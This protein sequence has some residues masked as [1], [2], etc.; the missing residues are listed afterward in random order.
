M[1][2]AA[3]EWMDSLGFNE[4]VAVVSGKRCGVQWTPWM[5][6]WFNSLSPRN[7]NS[8]AEGPWDH[9]V[10]LA[11]RILADPMTKLVRPEVYDETYRG[12]DLYSAAARPLTDE[13]LHERFGGTND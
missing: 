10:D 13:E 12:L 8:N 6:D 5:G 9:W 1:V 7:D 4:E 2:S 11:L 3:R